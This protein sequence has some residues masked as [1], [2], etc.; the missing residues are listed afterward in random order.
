MP[1]QKY[2]GMVVHATH[3]FDPDKVDEF[4][5]HLR[6]AWEAAIAEPENLLFDVFVDPSV[7]GR[8]RLMEVWTKDQEWFMNVRL[9][10]GLDEENP[11]GLMSG[12]GPVA[13][14]LL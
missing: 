8:V 1:P 12:V 10:V 14:T 5:E 3:Y 6:P 2:E 9:G 13:E 7:P 11:G 4:L